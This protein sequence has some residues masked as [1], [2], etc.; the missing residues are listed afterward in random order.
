[1]WFLWC[2]LTFLVVIFSTSQLIAYVISFIRYPYMME[3]MHKKDVQCVI[4]GLIL[5]SVITIVWTVI[6]CVISSIRQHW[7]AIIISVIIGLVLS[8]VGI[9]SD[10]KLKHNFG[11]VT[12]YNRRKKIEKDLNQLVEVFKCKLNQTEEIEDEEIEDNE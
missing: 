8:I 3:D 5:H 1:M 12:G 6:V 9:R 10:D 7:I 2:F 11:E 4:G